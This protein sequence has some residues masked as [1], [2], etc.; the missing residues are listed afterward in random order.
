[1]FRLFHKKTAEKETPLNKKVKEMKCRKISFVYTDFDEFCRKMEQDTESV[2]EL[3]PVNYYAEKN[4]YIASYIYT[5][6]DFSENYIQFFR[7][8]NERQ[9]VKSEIYPVDFNTLSKILAKV[10]IIINSSQE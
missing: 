10:G 8:E 7:I 9:C 1:M 6:D 3:V 2:S 5:N 4:R